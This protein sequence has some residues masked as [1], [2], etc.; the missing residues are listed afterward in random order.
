MERGRKKKKIKEFVVY[1]TTIDNNIFYGSLVMGISS[2][3]VST[4]IVGKRQQYSILCK[5]PE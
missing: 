3:W 5:E 1:A 4:V 2:P